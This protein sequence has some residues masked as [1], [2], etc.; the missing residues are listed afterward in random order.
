MMQEVARAPMDEIKQ[1]F[2]K[3]HIERDKFLESD[4]NAKQGTCIAIQH[5]KTSIIYLMIRNFWQLFIILSFVTFILSF[6]I[7][8]YLFCKLMVESASYSLSDVINL[9]YNYFTFKYIN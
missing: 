8:H 5:S 1:A 7:K 2:D 9:M 6:T 3:Y 4:I